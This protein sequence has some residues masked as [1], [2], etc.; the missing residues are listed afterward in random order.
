M[1][2]LSYKCYNL[3][4]MS[5]HY[6]P[7]INKIIKGLNLKDKS[8]LP[9]EFTS[10]ET[11]TKPFITVSREPGSGGAP[12][13]KLVAEKF[14]FDFIDEQIVEEIAKSTKKRKEVIAAVDEKKR[15]AIDDMVHSLLNKD[16]VD[17]FKYISELVQ[18]VLLYANQGHTV[19]LGRG[20][21]FITPF[22]HG[23]HVRITAPYDV[24]VQR[25]IDYEGFT[26]K[27][28]KEVIAKVEK[29]RKEFVKQYFNHN[30]TKSN[31]YDLT[32]NTTLFDIEDARDII[33]K[34]FC[35]KFKRFDRYMALL[36]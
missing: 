16:Y 2:L 1:E 36:K 19:I 15:G 24:R 11:F 3:F 7:L 31:G 33:V 28:A 25:A 35:H 30:L 5:I 27:Q 20:A 8:L 32:I 21:N 10:E 26:K 17:D 29:E 23:L 9:P 18:V 6:Y 22:A 13:A 12:I 34:A 14:G 4:L